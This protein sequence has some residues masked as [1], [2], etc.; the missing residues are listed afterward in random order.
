VLR[1]VA[2][3]FVAP[4]LAAVYDANIYS[5]V[6]RDSFIN[7][8]L[9]IVIAES[10]LLRELQPVGLGRANGAPD[11]YKTNHVHRR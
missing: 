8:V 7:W 3:I 2:V 10:T 1:V 4:L 5:R 9:Q 11:K 6:W